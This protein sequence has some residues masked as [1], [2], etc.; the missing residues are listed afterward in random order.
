MIGSAEAARLL[1]VDT[2][3]VSR[4]SDERLKP[5]ARALTPVKKL[6]GKRGPKLFAR[7]DV[8]ALRDELKRQ[9]AT[10]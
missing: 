7:A 2:S 3:T 9:D 8:E 1:E 5:N 10:R 6:G 4:W